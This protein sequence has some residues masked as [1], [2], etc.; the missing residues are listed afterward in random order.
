MKRPS[1]K[2]EEFNQVLFFES[3]PKF[4]GRQIISF[5]GKVKSADLRKIEK[6]TGVKTRMFTSAD[7]VSHMMSEDLSGVEGVFLEKHGI[8]LIGMEGGQE[9]D[10]PQRLQSLR[11][12]SQSQQFVVEDE[13]VVHALPPVVEAKVMGNTQNLDLINVS[14]TRY[15]GKGVK[16]AVLDTGFEDT[17][18]D[19]KD[20]SLILKSFLESDGAPTSASPVD[21]NG[22]GTHCIGLAC[23][24][25]NMDGVQYGIAGESEIYSLK[26]LDDDG[27]GASFDIVAAILWAV[28]NGCKVISMSLGA[29]TL[30][31]QRYFSYY[32]EAGAYALKNNSIVVA[33]AGN[34]SRRNMGTVEPVSSPANSPSILAVGAV[35]L[36]KS[37]AVFSNGSINPDQKIDVVAPGV[38]VYSTF[39]NGGY[40]N[41]SGTSMAT[42]HVAGVLAL[43]FEKYPR[44][45]P[46]EII[47]RMSMGSENLRQPGVDV[48]MGLVRFMK[49]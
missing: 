9:N 8:G 48:G 47:G 49:E 26:V 23:G 13:I 17:H 27:T 6:S 41:L 44:A 21:K 32:E 5:K 39:I 4:T 20:R 19:F 34:D 11:S 31:N 43:M 33:A 7:E 12:M 15:T 14:G 35:D 28:D 46:F 30:P 24:K 37:V 25:N 18:P 29:R 2:K 42:P 16:V 3:G 36:A 1:L 45:K 22:H 38:N 40:K 10:V